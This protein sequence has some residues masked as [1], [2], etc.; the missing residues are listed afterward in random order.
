MAREDH[1]I[2]YPDPAAAAVVA[3]RRLRRRRPTLFSRMR[4]SSPSKETVCTNGWLSS[5]R[6][7][8]CWRQLSLSLPTPH[9]TAPV[10]AV[11][12]EIRASTSRTESTCA[13]VVSKFAASYSL[14]LLRVLLHY[15]SHRIA[16][17]FKYECCHLKTK[18]RTTSS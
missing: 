1:S 7:T 15:S 2:F 10:P 5:P 6:T 17:V 11:W 12:P 18:S 9:M 4:R 8:A 14:P 13:F 16:C 3:A